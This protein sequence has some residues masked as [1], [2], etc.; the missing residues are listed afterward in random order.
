M[1]S[2][3]TI[4]NLAI[5][6]SALTPLFCKGQLNYWQKKAQYNIDYIPLNYGSIIIPGQS[7]RIFSLEDEVEIPQY[8]P[9]LSG[10]QNPSELKTYR[11]LVA[12]QKAYI[13]SFLPLDTMTLKTSG[14]TMAN[15]SYSESSDERTIAKSMYCNFNTGG[16]FSFLNFQAALDQSRNEK[17]S[18][19][20]IMYTLIFQQS[21]PPLSEASKVWSASGKPWENIIKSIETNNDLS[22]RSE[23]FISAFGTHYILSVAVG[24]KIDILATIHS[25]SIQSQTK[26]SAAIKG[27]LGIGGAYGQAEQQFM[28]SQDIRILLRITCGDIEPSYG[29]L[30]LT[31]LKNVTD[32]LEKFKKNEIK[33]KPGPVSFI[34][35]SF[36]G[37]LITN[38][39]LHE[40]FN[41]SVSP[42]LT[43]QLPIGTILL[44]QPR[45]EDYDEL[46]NALIP[47]GWA[48]CD[49]LN[50][51]PNLLNRFPIG[52]P[53][54]KKGHIGN[55]V[56]NESHSH[57]YSGRTGTGGGMG[58]RGFD[59]RYLSEGTHTHAY[60]GQTSE[61]KWIPPSYSI[62]YI[63]KTN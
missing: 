43:D 60:S 24:F 9:F 63:V 16:A 45:T 40:I 10:L 36:N 53:D 2:S 3:K 13:S 8:S 33:M 4:I 52:S 29:S 35:S 7:T 20:T 17:S 21:G 62:L 14:L 15:G 34:A 6:I 28:E 57:G 50:G 37:T 42:I 59:D 19:K 58:A 49:G 61:E 54:A 31:N 51:R 30:V 56:G 27:M 55:S 38:Q 12:S 39:K 44:W 46:G 25:T 1:K 47:N 48:L 5:L 23:Q 11:N 26:F 18:S 41:A 22:S 32:F